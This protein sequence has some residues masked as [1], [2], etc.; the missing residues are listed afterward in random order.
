M[1]LRCGIKVGK[2]VEISG[3]WKRVE[4]GKEY[5]WRRGQWWEQGY[6]RRV[7]LTDNSNWKSIVAYLRDDN[8]VL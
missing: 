3:L 2:V 1:V 7:E 8:T 6:V 5:N 4:K